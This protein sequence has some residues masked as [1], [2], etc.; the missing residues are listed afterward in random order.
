MAHSDE[1]KAQVFAA[2]LAGGTV[3]EVA[4]RYNL[5]KQTVSRIKRD[6]SPDE[7][8]QIGTE[9]RVRIDDLLLSCMAENLTALNKIAKA[10]SDPNYIKN[11]PAESVAVLYR[12]IASVTVRL[13]EAASAAGVGE[14][15]ADSG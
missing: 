4:T 9:K 15:S 7:M 2:L 8:V 6:L 1:V 5:P 11:Q 14:C 3:T 10:S 13:L 12:E